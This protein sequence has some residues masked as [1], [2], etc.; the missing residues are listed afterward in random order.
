M[1]PFF[2]SSGDSAAILMQERSHLFAEQLAASQMQSKAAAAAAAA[3]GQ[4]AGS[5]WRP[6]MNP[7]QMYN[8]LAASAAAC[9]PWYLAAL[10]AESSGF[11]SSFPPGQTTPLHP[12]LP[13]SAGPPAGVWP[14]HAASLPPGLS[15]SDFM[16]Q[17]IS[18]GSGGLLSPRTESSRRPS[19]PPASV[20]Y[21]PYNLIARDGQKGPPSP[22]QLTTS[23]SIRSSLDK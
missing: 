13:A 21:T 16:R 10:A 22:L 1:P 7:N 12:N 20:R 15:F 11:R 5:S 4:A 6:Q 14:P 19:P 17:S 3:A 23:S 9:S 18:S 2:L 8:L